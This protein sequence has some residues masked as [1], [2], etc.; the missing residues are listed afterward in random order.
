MATRRFRARERPQQR[1]HPA[2]RLLIDRIE[3]QKIGLPGDLS[4]P[5]GQR[6][7]LRQ[8]RQIDE[9]DPK[10]GLGRE[11]L[12]Q[13]GL[14]HGRHRMAGHHGVAVDP[15]AGLA[16]AGEEIAEGDVASQGRGADRERHRSV[17]EDL[18]PE[19]RAASPMLPTCGALSKVEQTL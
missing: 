5:I 4:A 15:I 10:V 8:Q 18:Q 13:I 2:K 17:A 11:V 3:Q 6:L 9:A 12:S 1:A 7:Q 14:V 19:P 16:D